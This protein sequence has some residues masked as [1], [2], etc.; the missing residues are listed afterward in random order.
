MR[1]DFASVILS[2]FVCDSVNAPTWLEGRGNLRIFRSHRDHDFHHLLV[3]AEVDVEL[4][5]EELCLDYVI[6]D[7]GFALGRVEPAKE[8]VVRITHDSIEGDCVHG[9][10]N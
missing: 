6:D 2:S 4:I 9:F 5:G 10:L 7:D 3:R 8:L 1:L